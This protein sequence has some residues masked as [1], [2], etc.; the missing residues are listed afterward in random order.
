MRRRTQAAGELGARDARVELLGPL[1]VDLRE[2]G[3]RDVFLPPSLELRR[4]LERRPRLVVVAVDAADVGIAPGRTRCFVGRLCRNQ[5]ARSRV[6]SV[7][8]K[9]GNR[10]K[11]SSF[12]Q[13]TGVDFSRSSA[14]IAHV[15]GRKG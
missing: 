9:S 8:F 14:R 15:D 2:L 3:R 13:I 7:F 5:R 10:G 4:P 6:L 1:L 12:A 11:K